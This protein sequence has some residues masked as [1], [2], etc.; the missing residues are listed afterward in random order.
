MIRLPK[1]TTREPRFAHFMKANFCIVPIGVS[2]F[3]L[4]LL[5]NTSLTAITKADISKKRGDVMRISVLERH[6]DLFSFPGCI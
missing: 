1:N 6:Q 5:E 2:Y 4:F 3:V